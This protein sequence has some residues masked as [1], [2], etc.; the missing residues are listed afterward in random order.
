M[1]RNAARAVAGT[2][3]TLLALVL[4]SISRYDWNVSALLRID[5]TF[6]EHF[7]VPAGVVLFE[8]GGYDGMLYYQIAR[9]LP[10]LLRGEQKPLLYDNAY[11]LQRI[12]LPALAS[13]LSLGEERRLPLAMLLIN[14]AAVVGAL[15]LL[16]RHTKQFS[17]HAAALLCNPAALVG[18][19]FSLTEPL[20]LLLTTAFLIRFIENDKRLDDTQLFLLSLAMFARETTVV[21]V[22]LLALSFLWKKEGRQALLVLTPLLSF[23]FWE[24]LL[25]LR[26]GTLPL[27]TGTGMVNVPLSGIWN[28]FLRAFH[29][30][31]T[32]VFSSLSFLLLFVLPLLALQARQW[33]M[34][35]R[36]GALSLC[37]TGFS[38]LLL[39]LDAHIW[40]TITSVGRVLPALYPVYVMHAVEHDT[41]LYRFLSSTLIA[42]SAV[43]AFGIALISHPFI[44]T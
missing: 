11:R 32:Y 23:A 33:I 1:T 10:E 37:L 21:L 34:E 38:F 4:L 6:G 19:L 17:V 30:P 25:M 15:C 35:R 2:T 3:I 14:L 28:L 22:G 24:L 40:G 12:L 43:T 41:S 27:S 36:I 31:N 29:E 18:V 9:D 39:T 16:L 7:H 20:A 42:T 13:L 44:V 5:R 26:F 8:D